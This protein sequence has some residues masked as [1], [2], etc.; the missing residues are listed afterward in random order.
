MATPCSN[1]AL[2]IPKTAPL[3][4]LSTVLRGPFLPLALSLTLNLTPFPPWG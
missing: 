1:L 2:S 3:I 4:C